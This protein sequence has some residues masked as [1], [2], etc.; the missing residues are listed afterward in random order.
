MRHIVD[1]MAAARPLIDVVAVLGPEHGFRGTAQAGGAEASFTDAKTGLPV[2]D[3]YRKG[4]GDLQRVFARAG[5]EVLLFDMQDIGTRFYTYIW[6][7]YDLLVAAAGASPPVAVV[8]L[9]R[10]NPIGG[11][12]VDGPV[13]R[14][15]GHSSFVGRR[16]LALR[17]GMTV[18][19]LASLFNAEYVP[20]ATVR[21][22]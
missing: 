21:L 4:A 1:V 17:H 7:L 5:I 19:E 9:D 15:E 6:T 20:G 8:V 3:T 11:V 2:Y 10:P 16:P 22:L 13:N 14:E 12:A 18:G